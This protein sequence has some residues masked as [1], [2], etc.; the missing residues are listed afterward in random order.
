MEAPRMTTLEALQVLAQQRDDRQLVVTNQQAARVWPRIS[1]HPLDFNYVPSTMGG[2][3]PLALGFALACPDLHVV[4]V[5]GDGSLL[6]SLG[7][8]VS[9]IDAGVTNLSIVVLENGVYEVTG[10][11]R[12]PA[13]ASRTDWV[14]LGRS[15][16]FPVSLDF[17]QADRWRG[18]A[19]TLLTRPGP[20]FVCLHVQ[21]ACAPEWLY[22]P[23]HAVR[24]LAR[25]Q[26][27][28]GACQAA[29]GQRHGVR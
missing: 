26:E 20:R 29:R 15:V 12:T 3:I 17:F 25:L 11:Q 7:C 18:M 5:S 28:L 22:H 9:V 16:G 2:A 10:G 21:P 6:M 24:Q 1:D 13:G 14:A 8:L 4:C 19:A 23:P 27:A